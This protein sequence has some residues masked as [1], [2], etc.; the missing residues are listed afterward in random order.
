MLPSRLLCPHVQ[1]PPPV[2]EDQGPRVPQSPF[3]AGCLGQVQRR[4]GRAHDSYLISQGTLEGSLPEDLLMSWPG[5]G[6]QGERE[7]YVEPIAE[8]APVGS[9]RGFKTAEKERTR[10]AAES[11]M[12]L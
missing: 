11:G 5:E 4:K 1:Q 12:A 10:R 2:V 6:A 7:K 8:L 9:R 3:Q